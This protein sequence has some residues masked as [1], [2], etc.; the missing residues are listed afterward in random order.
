MNSNGTVNQAAYRE[1]SRMFL[2]AGYAVTFGVAFANLTGIFVR[3]GLYHGS[4]L[5]RQWQGTSSRDIH[6]RLMPLYRPVPGW[7]FAAVALLMFGLNV[8][9][10]EVHRRIRVS[11]SAFGQHGVQILRLRCGSTRI[12]VSVLL[13]CTPSCLIRVR[14][15][16]DT[17]LAHYLHIAPRTL[18]AA[19]GIATLIGALVQCGVAVFMLTRI[20]GVCTPEAEG[21]FTCPHGRVTYSSS[22]IW[23]KRRTLI[24]SLNLV[25]KCAKWILTCLQ[26]S[27]V[28]AAY[29]L[30]GKR[31][32]TY[33]GSCSLDL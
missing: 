26:V 30:Q 12:G 3:V 29:S 4:D 22:P 18:F 10:D 33:C 9:A 23:G 16:A 21:N 31:T 13:I 6:A 15:V 11:R 7:S 24:Y 17:K 1:Y 32:A 20:A 19:Q 25:A 8:V 5:W 28:P 27:S 2:P 14:F